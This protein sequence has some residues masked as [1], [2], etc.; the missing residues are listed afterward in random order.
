VASLNDDGALQVLLM[1]FDG[2]LEVLDAKTGATSWSPAISGG[3]RITGQVTL[4][5]ANQNTILLVPLGT[6]GVVAFDW[7]QR[8]EIW[9]SP[10]GAAVIATPVVADLAHDGERQV[11]LGTSSGEVLVLRLT[12]GKTL[13]R[14]K[15][16]NKLIAADP[17]VADLNHDGIDD[18]LIASHDFTLYAI[19]GREIISAWRRP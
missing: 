5:R 2:K 1:T 16:A 11:I 14:A 3:L 6:N 15:V 8:R 10:A 13:W 4:A 7:R 18:V 17:A 19:D 12:D 9:R